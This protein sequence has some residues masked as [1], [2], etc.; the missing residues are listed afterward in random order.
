MPVRALINFVLY[1]LSGIISTVI[2]IWIGIETKSAVA[3]TAALIA[4]SFVCFVVG[5]ATDQI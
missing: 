3:F 5:E 2:V 1:L 4:A